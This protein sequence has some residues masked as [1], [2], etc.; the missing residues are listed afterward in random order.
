MKKVYQ[1][2]ES[3]IVPMKVRDI[4]TSSTE[5]MVS[6]DGYWED[7]TPAPSTIFDHFN[8]YGY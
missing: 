5:G 2:P 4:L 1:T 7:P 6:I 3:K 8:N